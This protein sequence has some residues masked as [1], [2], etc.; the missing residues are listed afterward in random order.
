MRKDEL[1]IVGSGAMAC[2]FAARL[3]KVM[4]V[5]MLGTWQAGLEALESQ[6]VRFV[7]MDGQETRAK[8]EVLRKVDP[9]RRFKVALVL[10]KS[11][12]TKRATGDLLGCLDEDGVALTLQNGLGN[13]EILSEN[14][15]EERVSLGVTTNGATLLGPGL[16]RHGGEGTTYL[17]I[18][19]S[20]D[21]LAAD[22]LEAGLLVVREQDL[23]ALVWTKLAVN[24][25]I[26]PLTALLE[27]PNGKLLDH[28][29]ARELM[30]AAANEV[31]ALADAL[32]IE[33]TTDDPAAFSQEVAKRT[34]ANLSSMLQDIQRAAPTEIDAICGEISRRGVATGTPT[35]L[36]DHLW[37]LVSAKA[38]HLRGA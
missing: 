23:Q 7:E 10:V 36:N 5:A 11:W 29:P 37:K 9:E 20:L 35:A 3:S 38:A 1:L 25:A 34:A 18:K 12:Q 33:L 32:G 4:R 27:V 19:P 26:N 6:G 2:F 16:V 21:R 30:T 28:E 13:V 31:A 8:V 14:L 24:A 22:F 15:G 17:S